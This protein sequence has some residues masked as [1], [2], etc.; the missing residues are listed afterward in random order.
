M[1]LFCAGCPNSIISIFLVSRLSFEFKL[2]VNINF[3]ELVPIEEKFGSIGIIDMKYLAALFS[4]IP[5]AF[6]IFMNLS[7]NK[8]YLE[9]LMIVFSLNNMQN[10]AP[11]A[12]NRA[13]SF[14][15]SQ[16][17]SGVHKNLFK[18][19]STKQ[20]AGSKEAQVESML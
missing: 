20:M 17:S 7:I 5:N 4:L 18:K 16:R 12:I 14:R 3:K 8:K 15:Q 11:S 19:N 2:I 6:N 1:I 9:E 13:G 10:L